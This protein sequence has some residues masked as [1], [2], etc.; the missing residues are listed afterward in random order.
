MLW[1]VAIQMKCAFNCISTI[2]YYLKHK[3]MH[4][5]PTISL[6]SEPIVLNRLIN[7]GL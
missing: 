5:N 2:A 4:F 7:N 3:E 6:S 1:I